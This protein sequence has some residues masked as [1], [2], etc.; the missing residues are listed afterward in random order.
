MKMHHYL[1]E[2]CF[3]H[4]K[5]ELF[6]VSQWGDLKTVSRC[7]FGFR[8]LTALYFTLAA[9]VVG[10]LYV[11]GHQTTWLIFMANEST[12]LLLFRLNLDAALTLKAFMKQRYGE[13]LR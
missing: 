4:D 6:R 10:L 11:T 8:F 13:K 9:A 5:P 2:F 1:R 3:T 7:Y 12:L